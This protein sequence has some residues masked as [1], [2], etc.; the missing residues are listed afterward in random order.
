MYVFIDFFSILANA[1]QDQV[2]TAYEEGGSKAERTEPFPEVKLY[3]L[4]F[5]LLYPCTVSGMTND[6]FVKQHQKS[7]PSIP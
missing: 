5:G 2:N 1:M 4:C 7:Q 3:A 6:D